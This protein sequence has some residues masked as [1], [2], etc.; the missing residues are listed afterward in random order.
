MGQQVC[1]SRATASLWVLLSLWQPETFP[2]V[3]QSPPQEG[4]II[5][6]WQLSQHPGLRSKGPSLI[7]RLLS[8]APRS[9]ARFLVGLLWRVSV[10][11]WLWHSTPTPPSKERPGFPPTPIIVR[12]VNPASGPPL[13]L[14]RPC[15]TWGV[16]CSFALFSYFITFLR[17]FKQCIVSSC[18]FWNV[19]KR[20]YLRWVTFLKN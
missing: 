15:V 9:P 2:R 19:T 5:P 1:L 12:E 13:S 18:S 17:I 16:Y 3:F 11:Y 4:W 14:R 7:Q 20:S 6:K 10:G 8:T